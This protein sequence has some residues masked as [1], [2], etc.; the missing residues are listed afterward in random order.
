[1]SIAD[2]L[3]TIAENEQ[4]VYKAGRLKTLQDSKYMNAQVSGTAIAVNDVSPIEHSV[5]C[6]L[7]SDTITDFS[8]V[9]VSRHGKNLFDQDTALP[10]VEL[11]H[12]DYSNYIWT[13]QADGSFFS[14]NI[15][16]MVGG[17]WWENTNGYTGQMSLCFT[18]KTPNDDTGKLGLAISFV[19]TDDTKTSVYV[20]TSIDYKTYTLTS[21]VGKTVSYIRQSYQN[22]GSQHYIKDVMIAYGTD[23]NYK[24]YKEPTT[25]TST[26]DGTVE[27]VTSI[28]PNITLL[29]NNN[30]VV[31]NANYLRDI[32]TYIDNLKTNVALTGGN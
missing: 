13:K 4:K 31:I 18:A 32:D 30:D 9:E 27:S 2:K 14:G 20:E 16:T 6:K 23:V 7:T 3:Q 25:Y 12:P 19:Y 21:A 24:P 29:T 5:G 15:G 26:A 22:Y 17:K 28:A 10:K 11:I 8:G 1:M